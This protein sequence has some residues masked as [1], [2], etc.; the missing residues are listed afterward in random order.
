[1]IQ[2]LCL[3][4]LRLASMYDPWLGVFENSSRSFDDSYKCVYVLKN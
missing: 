1:M 4:T 2:Y 3:M